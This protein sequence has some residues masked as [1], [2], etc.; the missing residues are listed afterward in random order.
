MLPKPRHSAGLNHQSVRFLGAMPIVHG[1]RP[2]LAEQEILI[3]PRR[4]QSLLCG[5]KSMQFSRRHTAST[6][7]PV[8]GYRSICDFAKSFDMSS[9][10]QE[11]NEFRSIFKS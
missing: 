1:S 9:T 7:F 4:S 6:T 11:A 5:T 2:T 3:P 10:E 8:R